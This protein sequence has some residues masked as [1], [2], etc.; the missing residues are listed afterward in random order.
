M[1][2]EG[3]DRWVALVYPLLMKRYLHLQQFLADAPQENGKSDQ[4]RQIR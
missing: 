1:Y 3:N 4:Q 2:L